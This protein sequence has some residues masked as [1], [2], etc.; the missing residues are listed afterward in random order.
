MYCNRATVKGQVY[1]ANRLKME[2]NWGENDVLSFTRQY[3]NNMA[4]IAEIASLEE[5]QEEWEVLEQDTHKFKVFRSLYH[6]YSIY[7]CMI[8]FDHLTQ[9]STVVGAVQRTRS[10]EKS[11]LHA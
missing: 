5:W 4:A 1:H 11:A 2:K 9:V 3:F 7:N 6:C 8:D 10:D